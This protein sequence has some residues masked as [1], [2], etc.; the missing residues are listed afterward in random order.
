ML[1]LDFYENIVTHVD[2]I[3]N[4]QCG[5]TF[6]ENTPHNACNPLERG[7][8]CHEEKAAMQN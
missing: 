4:D 2:L 7:H 5:I 3:L 1:L 6:E 8:K